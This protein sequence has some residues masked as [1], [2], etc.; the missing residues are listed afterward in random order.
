MGLCLGPQ[1]ASAKTPLPRPPLNPPAIDKGGRR[2][3]AS[4][5]WWFPVL[6]VFAPLHA[7]RSQAVAFSG[8]CKVGGEGEKRGG[9]VGLL[10]NP[11]SIT[12]LAY[13]DS[14]INLG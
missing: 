4:L 14:N 6:G 9:N 2:R 12:S 13:L 7:V 3:C 5:G 1:G 11:L 10:T 8:V